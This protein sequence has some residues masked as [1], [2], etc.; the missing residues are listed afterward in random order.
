MFVGVALGRSIKVSHKQHNILW[1]LQFFIN[2]ADGS[3]D[4]VQPNLIV[5]DRVM[6][7]SIA[8]MEASPILENEL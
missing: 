2:P 7:V 6:Q 3:L 5:R 4:L 8:D 1:R